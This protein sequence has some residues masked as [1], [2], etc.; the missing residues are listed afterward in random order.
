[1][2]ALS[3]TPGRFSSCSSNGPH[4]S[5][6]TPAPPPPYQTIPLGGGGGAGNARRLTI[7]IYIYMHKYTYMDE[8]IHTYARC[9]HKDVHRCPQIYRYTDIYIYI[10][11]GEVVS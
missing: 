2:L 10:Q 5:P 1:M 9:V 8:C 6:H 7:Y 3:V 11:E 4:P